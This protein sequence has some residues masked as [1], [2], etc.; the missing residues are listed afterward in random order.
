VR[1]GATTGGPKGRYVANLGHV[2]DDES[3]LIYMR[4]RYYEPGTGRF[5]CED[6]A[7]DGVNWYT[8]CNNNPICLVDFSGTCG[9]AETLAGM[10]IL[11]EEEYAEATKDIQTY[12]TFARQELANRNEGVHRLAS[13]IGNVDGMS[14]KVLTKLIEKGLEFFKS[15]C[16]GT[17]TGMRNPD[18]IISKNGAFICDPT[19]RPIGMASDLLYFMLE[20][21]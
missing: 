14:K 13:R 15:S 7:Y 4:A 10:L 16:R 6:P 11:E 8:Y 21:L 5:I 1:S 9:L 18:V 17:G 2:Q 12:R 20:L 19:G 3:G